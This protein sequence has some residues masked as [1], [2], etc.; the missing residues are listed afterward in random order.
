MGTE[1]EQ[2]SKSYPK[3]GALEAAEAAEKS[4][5][6]LSASFLL[7][8]EAA[9]VVWRVFLNAVTVAIVPLALMSARTFHAFE[10]SST[11]KSLIP[12]L[13]RH[14]KVKGNIRYSCNN[15]I[16]TLIQ[17]SRLFLFLLFLQ[18]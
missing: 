12:D 8:W 15:I 9:I 1:E 5:W 3:E 10:T 16:T 18:N 4:P 6:K 11:P 7:S 2:V 14:L 17:I 13:V